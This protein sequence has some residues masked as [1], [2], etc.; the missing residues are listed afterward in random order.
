MT[1]Q[2]LLEILCSSN[3]SVE[4]ILTSLGFFKVPKLIWIVSLLIGLILDS[5]SSLIKCSTFKIPLVF[6]TSLPEDTCM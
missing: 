3:D 1:M 2:I 5:S 4:P 6:K